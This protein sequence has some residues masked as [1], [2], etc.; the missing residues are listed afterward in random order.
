MRLNHCIK[1]I[2][3]LVGRLIINILRVY[4]LQTDL[5]VDE[6]DWIYSALLSNISTVS[7][8]EYLPVCV[9]LNSHV[10]KPPEGFNGVNS[11]RGFGSCNADGTIIVDLC[12]VGNLAKTN[13]Y[14]MKQDKYLV[15][16]RSGNS[17]TQVGCILT[18]HS[19]LK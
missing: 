18:R 8:D 7:L 10:G 11:K 12:T 5:S 19:D 3:I 2:R 1:S 14:F 6:N 9:D 17:C 16:Y 13:T 4:K 15:T